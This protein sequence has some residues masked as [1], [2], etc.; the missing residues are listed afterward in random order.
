MYQAIVYRTK[1]DISKATAS[2][3]HEKLMR[4]F[5]KDGTVILERI[6]LK[7]L[8]TKMGRKYQEDKNLDFVDE[9]ERAKAIYD[10]NAGVVS[11]DEK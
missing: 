3:V 4:V 10:S 7:C 6:V 9:V 8:F 2:D 11:R 5:E 1:L